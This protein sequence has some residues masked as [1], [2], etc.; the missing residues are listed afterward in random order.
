MYIIMVLVSDVLDH[1]GRIYSPLILENT[2]IQ[3][4]K[5]VPNIALDNQRV[6]NFM[7]NPELL[8]FVFL[9]SVKP[10]LKNCII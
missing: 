1:I 2:K 7:Q 3:K 8:L 6:L 10:L 5:F 4:L 9:R